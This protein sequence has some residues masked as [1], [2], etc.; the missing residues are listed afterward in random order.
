MADTGRDR[1]E[2]PVPAWDSELAEG[3]E[4][5]SRSGT[6]RVQ[7][8][9]PRT[10][11]IVTADGVGV[12]SHAG[13]ALPAEVADRIGL[14]AAFSAA[15]DALRQRRCGHGPGRVLVNVAVAIADGAETISDVQAL[16]DQ[17]VLAGQLAS[18][19]TI[20]RVLAAVDAE[21]LAGLRAARAV[22]RGGPG[23]PAGSRRA[24]RPVRHRPWPGPAAGGGSVPGPR[25]AAAASR[26][27][28]R[29]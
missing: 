10:D 22:A 12:V 18:T 5:P 23:W 4:S 13:T 24:R 28:A 7:T 9:T 6:S 1:A 16:A 3:P 14:T 19:A 15:L 20:W 17:S 29:R 11:P 21:V 2:V 25:P 27:R 26:R 8:T